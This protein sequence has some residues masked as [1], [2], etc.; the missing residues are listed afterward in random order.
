LSKKINK[1]EKEAACSITIRSDLKSARKDLVIAKISL[2]DKDI[3]LFEIQNSQKAANKQHS[4]PPANITSAPPKKLHSIPARPFLIARVRDSVAIS[5][6]TESKIDNLLGSVKDQEGPV[7][8]QLKSTAT[9]RS[10]FSSE[11]N[12]TGTKRE[13]F[14][15]N[16][17]KK[18]SSK[19]FMRHRIATQPF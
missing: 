5:S 1:L 19:M 14:W 13:S 18:R 15:I 10:T 7:V 11:M 4:A 6:I 3:R 2:A 8:Q 17:R 16:Q 9:T 12:K